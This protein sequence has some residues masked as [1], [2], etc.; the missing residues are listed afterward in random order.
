MAG[1][2]DVSSLHNARALGNQDA[3]RVD[4]VFI[5][6]FP[7]S[8]SRP[9][10]RGTHGARSQEGRDPQGCSAAAAEVGTRDRPFEEVSGTNKIS[11][12]P[13]YGEQMATSIQREI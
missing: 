5:G 11:A 4:A 6:F 1:V 10:I 7:G 3:V 8:S 2:E 12:E 13:L 9:P